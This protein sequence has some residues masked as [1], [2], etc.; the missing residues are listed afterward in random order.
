MKM[1]SFIKITSIILAFLLICAA[2]AGCSSD[3]G[4][5]LSLG[6]SKLSLN[7]YEFLLSRM[8]GT[9]VLY[10]VDP[11]SDT[12]WNTVVSS[13]GMTSDEYYRT[14]ILHE[15]YK[16][17]EALYIFSEKNLSLPSD[18][19]NA[20]DERLSK[21]VKTA[22]SKNQLNQSLS[23]YCMNY[24]MLR[25]MYLD[26]ARIAYLRENL[27]GKDGEKIESTVKEQFYNDNY[28]RFSQVFVA[29]Y[30]YVNETDANGDTVYYKPEGGIAYD[31]AL[32]KTRIDEFGNP[33]KDKNGDDIYYL[34]NGKIAYETVIGDPVRAKNQ[35]GEYITAKYEGDELK[36]IL[37]RAKEYLA[38]AENMT[39]SMFDEY[40]AEFSES[41]EHGKTTLRL[42]DGYYSSKSESSAYLDN[43][44]K[45]LSG[46]K[47]GGAELITSDYG[48]HIVRK[49]SLESGAYESRTDTYAD[50]YSDLMDTLF[51]QECAKYDEQVEIDNEVY[52][53]SL[54]MAEIGYNTLY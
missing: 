34:E 50:F 21:L 4:T 26:E 44:A 16:Y 41:E 18:R 36:A 10:G 40:V 29:T 48:Y 38:G 9:L 15:A 51:G 43:I 45:T 47:T 3:S 19:I 7:A 12:F 37:N 8:K 30:Y 54:T 28:V 13:D 24:D 33:V 22:G 49:Y 42:A 35:N 11:N 2:F 5:L 25:R 31:K 23:A 17:V 53:E 6:S 52:A 1:R 39:D 32:G 20:V 14:T 27:Y 46:M